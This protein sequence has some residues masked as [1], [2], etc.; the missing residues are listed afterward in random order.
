MQ[1][2]E[3][4]RENPTPFFPEKPGPPWS[5]FRVPLRALRGLFGP[6]WAPLEPPW[7]PFEASLWPLWGLHGPIQAPFRPLSGPLEAPLNCI[8]FIGLYRALVTRIDEAASR[9]REKHNSLSLFIRFAAVLE[10]MKP[11][12]K[13]FTINAIKVSFLDCIEKSDH[14]TPTIEFP[15]NDEWRNYA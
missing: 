14:L 7:G 15:S 13:Q 12:L 5:L 9:R 6:P 4:C 3:P 10:L 11:T 2:A 8:V 1:H